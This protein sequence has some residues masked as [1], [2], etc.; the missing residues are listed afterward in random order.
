MEIFFIFFPFVFSNFSC[1]IVAY[2]LPILPIILQKLNSETETMVLI[3]MR[4]STIFLFF[5]ILVNNGA[6]TATLFV[7]N[8][9]KL[10]RYKV[11]W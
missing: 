1:I 4:N 3:C 11:G 6:R 10:H 9:L 2:I 5:F 7:L 8:A